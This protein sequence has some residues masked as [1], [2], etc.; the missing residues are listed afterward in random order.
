MFTTFFTIFLQQILY[1]K[2]LIA[3]ISEQKSNF[4]SEFKLAPVTT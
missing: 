1:D 3:V 2:L 4:S